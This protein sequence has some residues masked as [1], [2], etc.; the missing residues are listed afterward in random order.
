MADILGIH[1]MSALSGPAQ[2]TLDFYTEVL[3]LRLVKLTVNFDDPGAY[4]LYF[5][6]GAGSPGT[7]L[8]FFPYPDGYPG[9]P[10]AGQATVTTLSV[11]VGSIPY[12]LER[13]RQEEVDFDRPANRQGIQYLSFRAPDGLLLELAAS[14]DHLAPAPW[15]ASPVPE[16][17]RPGVMR[18]L[19]LVERNVEPTAAVLTELMGFTK[20]GEY[21]N[22]HRF[23]LGEG[24]VGR[25]IDILHDPSGPSGR[26][27]HGSVH[28]I[29]FRVADL[30]AQ[31]VARE[32]VVARGLPVSQVRNRDYF[33]SIY[34]R[35]PGGVLFEIATDGP[36]FAVDES[37]ERLGSSL[38]L[39]KMH[40]PLRKKIE[41][42]LPALDL[43]IIPTPE[44]VS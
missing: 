23:E 41:R 43:P 44:V 19:T 26:G 25:T 36:G 35:E 18:S 12:W 5:G 14:P 30:E 10:G 28:H 42:L 38:K 7:L 20:T 15:R 9:R 37:P 22:R 21:G 32:E 13:F 33:Q 6:D 31:A 40:E 8:T 39:P 27:G 24:G 34:F 16:E 29:A 11:P 1:H 4:H 2:E 3:G 17:Y